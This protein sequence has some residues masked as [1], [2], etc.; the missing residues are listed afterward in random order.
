MRRLLN[1]KL[2]II[3]LVVG[4]VVLVSGVAL[5]ATSTGPNSSVS[6]Q[7]AGAVAIF[8]IPLTVPVGGELKVAG[9][10]FE[11]GE[12]VL[13]QIVTGT[14]LPIFLQGGQANNAGAFLADASAN[15]PSG[16]LPESLEPGV[17]TIRAL[18]GFGDHVASA[19][20]VICLPDPD[21]GKCE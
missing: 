8:S 6:E 20:L 2:S 21:S 9:A 4:A 17:Y 12:T 11:A 10:G 3:A 18:S 13:F 5:A 19:P 15:S 14:G 7:E 1:S 16:G